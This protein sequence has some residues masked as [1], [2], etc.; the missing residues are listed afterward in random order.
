MDVSFILTG[1][2]DNYTGNFIDRFRVALSKNLE[3]LNRSDLKYEFIIVD[4]NPIGNQLLISNPKLSHLLQSDNI[5]N[6]IVDQSVLIDDGLFENGFYEYF[7]KN[8]G[9]IH[10]NGKLLFMT[11]A[12]IIISN[13]IVNY[14]KESIENIDQTKFHRLR[15]R[16]DVYPN[17]TMGDILDL[18]YPNDED[19]PICGV[20]SGDATIFS[21]EMFIDVATGYNEIDPNHRTMN[22]QASMDGEILWN[23]IKKG[24]SKKLVDLVYYHVS[25]HRQSK[26]SSYSRDEYNNRPNWG[27]RKYPIRLINP[28]T[29]EIYK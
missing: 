4:Y 5:K 7:G 17:N 1:R 22:G 25:H 26:D 11:N 16:R 2:D 15:Y 18:Y 3:I 19:E 28:N 24:K 13:E 27:C 10:S 23:L 9:A 20:Y 29:I 14:L 6:I 12:D 8:V 21:R